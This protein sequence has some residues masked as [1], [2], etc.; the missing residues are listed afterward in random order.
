VAV[1]SLGVTVLRGW[2]VRR[3]PRAFA[4]ANGQ[5]TPIS[6]NRL[7]EGGHY[8]RPR[9]A[10]EAV[11]RRIAA[12]A[13]AAVLLAVVPGCYWAAST[14]PYPALLTFALVT[15]CVTAALGLLSLMLGHQRSAGVLLLL[16]AIAVPNF[17]AEAANLPLFIVSLLLIFRSPTD[18]TFVVE[19]DRAI[20]PAP[21]TRRSGA[22][23]R[24]SELGRSG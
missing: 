14:K 8:S 3:S 22:P 21:T 4:A 1:G 20:P 6:V 16:A 9:Y 19:P 12:L 17:F 15:G 7:L 13:P 11:K 24:R 5:R 18:S 10:D 2:L 23:V